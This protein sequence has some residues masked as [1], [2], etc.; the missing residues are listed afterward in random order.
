MK[1]IHEF[2]CTYLHKAPVD[3]RKMINGLAAIVQSE[4]GTSPFGGGLFAFTS[5]RR[6]M[7]KLLYWDKSGFALWMKRL[8]KE[9]FRWPFK[10]DGDV[11]TLS[12]QQLAWL[13]DGIDITRMKPHATLGYLAVS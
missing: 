6:D 2:N 10:M 13:L 11:V 9:K 5:R 12:S 7:I 1:S 3:G 4:M 8:E